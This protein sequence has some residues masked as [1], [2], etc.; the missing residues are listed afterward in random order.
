MTPDEE[1]TQEDID[2]IENLNSI[3]ED[4]VKTAEILEKLE[5]KYKNELPEL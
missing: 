2:T 5:R 1:I 3:K 4:L